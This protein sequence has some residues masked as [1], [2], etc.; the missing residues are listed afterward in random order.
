MRVAAAD[1]PSSGSGT[2]ASAETPPRPDPRGEEDEDFVP[3]E[4]EEASIDNYVDAEDSS[5]ASSTVS[6]EEEDV[7]LSQLIDLTDPTKHCLVRMNKRVGT[8]QV[9]CVCG[10]H[11]S[12]CAT[13]GHSDKRESGNPT[14][15]GVPAFSVEF[16]SATGGPSGAGR[17]DVRFYSAEEV[18]FARRRHQQEVDELQ[19]DLPTDD[20]SLQPVVPPPAA[21]RS[22][23]TPRPRSG[24]VGFSHP[25]V[26]PDPRPVEPTP[27]VRNSGK[28]APKG[29]LLQGPPVGPPPT[30][31][32]WFCLTLL[33][34]RR[35]ATDTL[36]QVMELQV[37]GHTLVKVVSTQ[38]EALDWCH[39]KPMRDVHPPPGRN[40]LGGTKTP[41]GP[42]G[43]T[44]QDRLLSRISSMSVGRDP[45]EATQNI[46]GIPPAD[47]GR[48]DDFLL[49]PGLT[50]PDARADFY[51]LA[52]DV[53]SLP[54]GYRLTDDDDL[55]NN[56]ALLAAIG[57]GR[58]THFRTWRRNTHNQLSRI[59]SREELLRFVTDVEKTVIRTRS[60]Q[61]QRMRKYLYSCSHD[62]SFVEL[63]VSN[64][65]LPRLIEQT[66]RDFL[67]L[68]EA[69]RSA[70]FEFPEGGWKGSYIQRMLQHHSKELGHIRL[71]A[72]DY[73]M[74]LLE[75][76]V[77]LRNA[78]KEKFQDPSFM[79]SLLYN[80]GKEQ[81][82]AETGPDENGTAEEPTR[83]GHCRRAGLHKGTTKD[84]CS[85]KALS[86]NKAQAAVQGLNRNQAKKV[87][88][89]INAA[90]SATPDGNVD[91]IVSKARAEA[92]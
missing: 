72:P 60:A 59:T 35:V 1:S 48:M 50:D 71:T 27:K 65:P 20:E 24:V 37:A 36:S 25:L 9:P 16:V 75:T 13:R 66:Y 85:L 61:E 52:M 82:S 68:L 57:K 46:Y 28:P 22:Y 69:L 5:R 29:K 90:L 62:T 33:E 3:E 53:P 40:N 21:Q 76:Y 12:L 81:S 38:E 49:P 19:E 78:R 87:A 42:P 51:D 80:L 8:K 45:S 73:R 26:E 32:P 64:G 86:R 79:R 30:S 10:T 43:P 88:K 84:S 89:L 17:T 67:A 58:N 11:P 70:M 23:S 54:G 74:H 41:V 6:I 15:L 4:E 31:G 91:S 2:D 47:E 77:Y 34:G 92:T 39:E 55:T 63:Y 14:V 7:P 44:P 83:C 18:T 56:E